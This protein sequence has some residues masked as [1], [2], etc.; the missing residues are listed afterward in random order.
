MKRFV[1]LLTLL[2]ASASAVAGTPNGPSWNGNIGN[3]GSVNGPMANGTMTNGGPANGTSANGQFTNG[4]T[5]QG[6][7]TNGAGAQGFSWG[8]TALTSSA[9]AARGGRLFVR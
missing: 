2:V 1:L 9:V 7:W 5:G 3:G 8:S 4:P 6:R